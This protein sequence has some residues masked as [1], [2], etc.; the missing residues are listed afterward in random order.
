MANF[1]LLFQAIIVGLDLAAVLPFFFFTSP[2]GG[3][4]HPPGH[5]MRQLAGTP[6]TPPRASFFNFFL[7]HTRNFLLQ[8]I[9]PPPTR[10]SSFGFDFPHLPSFVGKYQALSLFFGH[11]HVST[12][13]ARPLPAGHNGGKRFPP[14]S[15]TLFSP[16]FGLYLL[17]CQVGVFGYHPCTPP[18]DPWKWTKFGRLGSVIE[19]PL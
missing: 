17:L 3:E 2:M 7:V 11:M 1:F 9:G 19:F 15:G 8:K 16:C 18:I 14:N 12:F 10:N 13:Y 6:F 4:L 5:R